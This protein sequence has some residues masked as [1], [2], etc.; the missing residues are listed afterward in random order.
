MSDEALKLNG[1]GS[2]IKKLKENNIDTTQDE[3]SSLFLESLDDKNSVEV[4]VFADLL[5]KTYSLNST[6][7]IEEI[8]NTLSLNDNIAEVLSIDDIKIQEEFERKL[9]SSEFATLLDDGTKNAMIEMLEAIV[10][11]QEEQLNS[12]KENNGFIASAWDWLKNTT[13]FGAGSAKAQDKIDDLKAQI[14]ALK[15]DNSKLADV[16]KNVIGNELT[17]DEFLKICSNEADFSN[18]EVLNSVSKY[19]QGQKCL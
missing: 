11:N 15:S 10:L 14:E 4:S 6:S 3:L 12:T 7:D 13:G 17:Q 5:A 9:N 8:L 16:Y 1:F 19:V 2:V 18:S